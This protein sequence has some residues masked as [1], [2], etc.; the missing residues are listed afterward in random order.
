ME[1]LRRNIT[2]FN[3]FER[4]CL[5][6]IKSK[7]KNNFE[8]WFLLKEYQNKRILYYHFT[9]ERKENCLWKKGPNFVGSLK[10]YIITKNKVPKNKTNLTKQILMFLKYLSLKHT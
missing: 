9:Q 6:L 4:P 2:A 8:Y 7:K 1:V 3:H 10:N 5:F